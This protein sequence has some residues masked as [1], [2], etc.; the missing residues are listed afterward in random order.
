M[1]NPFLKY[2]SLSISFLPAEPMIGVQFINTEADLMNK[3]DN[4]KVETIKIYGI[5]LGLFFLTIDFE[6]SFK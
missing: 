1:N 3:E 4:S 6:L 2:L 5:E